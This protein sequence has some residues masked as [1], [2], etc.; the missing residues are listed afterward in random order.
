[1][2]KRRYTIKKLVNGEWVTIVEEGLCNPYTNEE[3]ALTD[4]KYML[5][6]GSTRLAM[7]VD[8]VADD[9]TILPF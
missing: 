6:E 8:Q 1:M 4:M 2:S 3:A 7:F 9:G 5:S